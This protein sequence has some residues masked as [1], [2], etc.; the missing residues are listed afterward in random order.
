M[1]KKTRY[2]WFLKVC[3]LIGLTLMAGACQNQELCQ[4]ATSTPLRIGFYHNVNGKAQA[5]AIDSLTVYGLHNDS[6]LYNNRKQVSRIELPLN[7]ALD[8]S[9][10]VLAFPGVND[11]LHITYKR[12]PRLISMECGFVTFYQVENWSAAGTAIQTIE[13]EH[14][15]ISNTL[16]EH[17]KLFPHNSPAVR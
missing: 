16:D 5:L 2:H 17:F 13:I 8:Q 6:I 7:P 15:S 12:E 3:G 11:T 10:F 9:S 14:S 1:K 4:D